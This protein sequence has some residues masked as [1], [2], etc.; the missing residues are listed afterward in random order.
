MSADIHHCP[1]CHAQSFKYWHRLTP[2]IVYALVKFKRAVIAK[3][4]NSVHTRKDMDGTANEL[5]KGEYANWTLLRYH[6]LVAKD[7]KA[8]AGYWLLTARGN[9]FLKGL[10]AVPQRVQTLNNHVIDHDD[11]HVTIDQVI[12]STPFFEEER[13]REPIALDGG[14]VALL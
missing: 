8:G 3:G 5:T 10:E 9:A 6:A 13:E 1:T 4:E 2:G 7:D 12:G 14:Q 11:V